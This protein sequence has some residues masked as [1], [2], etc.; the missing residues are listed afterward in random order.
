MKRL[1]AD[2]HLHTSDDP[3]DRIDYSAEILIDTV[4]ENG[5]DVMAITSHTEVIFNEYLAAYARERGVLL[6]PAVELNI[7][8][9]NVLLLNPD[10][11]QARATT[12]ADLR[13]L[14]KRGGGRHRGPS[15][16]S[17]PLRLGSQ[18]CRAYRSV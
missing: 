14:G 6:I 16:L 5:L 18:T 10:T 11:E 3:C 12:F 8:K 9:K 13:R 2:L 15:F 1:K 4:A 17:N 7:E